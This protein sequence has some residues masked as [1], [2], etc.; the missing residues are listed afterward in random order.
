MTAFGV[1][2]VIDVTSCLFLELVCQNSCGLVGLGQ[3][4]C[5]FLRL[6]E[7]GEFWLLGNVRVSGF[8]C[9]SRP[10]FGPICL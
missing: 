10:E 8:I 6:G 7:R 5:D 1:R 2:D 4:W 9:G 3:W